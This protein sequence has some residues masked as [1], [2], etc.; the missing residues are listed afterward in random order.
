M[1]SSFGRPCF[2]ARRRATLRWPQPPGTKHQ[3]NLPK[4]DIKASRNWHL[5]A[6]TVGFDGQSQIG[7]VDRRVGRSGVA[8]IDVSGLFGKDGQ[9]RTM[10][11]RPQPSRTT[12][13]VMRTDGW[14]SCASS[15]CLA[16]R[17]GQRPNTEH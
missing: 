16:L 13:R 11:A 8:C 1:V 6:E 9:K 17:C 7:P 12:R 4:A 10:K 15:R 2:I 5:G 14:L 3:S